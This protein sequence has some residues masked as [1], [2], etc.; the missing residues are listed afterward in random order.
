MKLELKQFLERNEQVACL[1]SLK[2]KHRK[3][4]CVKIDFGTTNESFLEF[5]KFAEY[6]RQVKGKITLFVYY[7]QLTHLNG[8]FFINKILFL[9]FFSNNFLIY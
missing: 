5:D 7:N 3:T 6:Y 1:K 8:R 4:D 9:Y 2:F